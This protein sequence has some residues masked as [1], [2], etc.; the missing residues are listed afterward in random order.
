MVVDF[1]VV[2]QAWFAIGDAT[3]D[4]AFLWGFDYVSQLNSFTRTEI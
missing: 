2:R 3:S 1:D 4:G